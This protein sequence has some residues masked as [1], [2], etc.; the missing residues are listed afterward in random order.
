MVALEAESG[1]G[2]LLKVGPTKLIIARTT[3]CTGDIMTKPAIT[4]RGIIGGISA[5][6]GLTATSG[7]FIST[8]R[9][10]TAPKT[11]V[12]ISGTFCGGWNWRRVADHL[13]KQGHK[14]FSPTLTGLGE[15][16]HLLSKTVD[17]DTH[18]A[19]IANVIKWENL[20]DACLVAHSYGGGPASGA[21]EHI[22]DRISSIVWLD[23]FKPEDGQPLLDMVNDATRKRFLE[24]AD[25]GE[26]SFPPAKSP[27]IVAVSEKD[28]GFMASKT[29]PHPIGI[30]LQPIKLTGAREKVAKKTFVRI[31]KFPYPA[32]DKAF[33]ECKADKSWRTLELTDSGHMAMLDAPERVT[34]ILL[35][36]A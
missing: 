13:E 19:D 23:A 14:V 15:R 36:A 7:G 33:A 34:D 5:T 21:L 3:L 29:T 24:M 18:I 11:F 25:K 8:A 27:P 2:S 22:G 30:Y 35:Q 1:L 12:L 26:I 32:L 20:T 4:R 6:V 31:P 10:Q 28:A 17:L 16:S 9:A